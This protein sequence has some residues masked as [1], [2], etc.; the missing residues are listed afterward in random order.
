MILPRRRRSEREGI[1]GGAGPGEGDPWIHGLETVEREGGGP[2]QTPGRN[3]TGCQKHTA[4]V[5]GA[6]LR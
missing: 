6:A 3:G 4:D 1:C 2:A 5:E